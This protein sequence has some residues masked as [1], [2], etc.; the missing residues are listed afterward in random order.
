MKHKYILPFLLV[1]LLFTA[2]RKDKVEYF[3][4]TNYSSLGKFDKNGLPNYIF[5]RDKIS[6]GL[7][8]FMDEYWVER[9]NL[10]LSHPELFTN[11]SLSEITILKK[12]TVFITFAQQNTN[13]NNAL[14]FY[15]YPTD[16]PPTSPKDSIVITCAFPNVGKGTPLNPGDKIKLGEFQPGVS[17]GFVLMVDGWDQKNKVINKNATLYYTNDILNPENDPGL[18]KHAIFVPY[19]AE[20]KFLIGFEDQS[21]SVSG[22]DHDFNDAVFYCTVIN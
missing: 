5:S 19:P 18:R 9:R 6:P 21:R 10:V 16:N 13:R 11:S 1:S 12:A 22:S 7:Q 20:N 8:N 14:G 15:T 17:I 3:T 4:D 2:C